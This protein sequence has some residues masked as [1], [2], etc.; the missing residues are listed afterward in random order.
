MVL[1]PWWWPGRNGRRS[2]P[3]CTLQVEPTGDTADRMSGGRQSEARD[4]PPQGSWPEPNGLQYL[5]CITGRWGQRGPRK[6]TA[7]SHPIMMTY[8]LAEHTGR[9]MAD[10]VC[11]PGHHLAHSWHSSPRG[12]G[13]TTCSPLQTSCGTHCPRLELGGLLITSRC[14]RGGN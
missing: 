6:V 8:G 12:K 2:L 11:R 4:P 9:D 3:G 10:S 5:E 7:H 14:Y 13:L 1:I